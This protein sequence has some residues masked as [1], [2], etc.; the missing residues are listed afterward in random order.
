MPFV[1]TALLYA[2]AARVVATHPPLAIVMFT[3]FG[4]PQPALSFLHQD[5]AP[6]IAAAIERGEFRLLTALETAA[7]ELAAAC[8]QPLSRILR[9]DPIPFDDQFSSNSGADQRI[10]AAQ[11]DAPHLWFENLNTPEDF[12]LAEAHVAAL[13]T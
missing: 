3:A 9:N 4:R 1:P 5:I 2:R 12:S 11:Q 6:F 13:D 7:S 10:T 8:G